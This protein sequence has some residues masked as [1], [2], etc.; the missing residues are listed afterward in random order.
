MGDISKN[1]DRAEFACK[2]G[3][4]FD[5]ID[6]RVVAMAQKIREALG[7][8]VRINSGC[9]CIEHNERVGGVEDSTHTLGKAADLST[10]V[11]SARLFAVI[12]KL[13]VRCVPPCRC[14]RPIVALL[15]VMLSYYKNMAL[16]LAKSKLDFLARETSTTPSSLW[17]L[18]LHFT[19]R[20]LR[21]RTMSDG[22]ICVV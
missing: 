19:T 21:I 16:N 14:L 8:P 12:R 4:G 10:A 13:F 9:R 3:C 5:N 20:K 7:E 15:G 2:C 6:D 22:A 17:N 1:F 18:L 11:G